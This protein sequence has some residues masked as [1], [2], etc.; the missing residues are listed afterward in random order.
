[1]PWDDKE[2]YLAPDAD[3]PSTC[4]SEADPCNPATG[5][6]T[7]DEIDISDNLGIG[8]SRHYQSRGLGEFGRSIGI[9]WSHS[10]SAQMYAIPDDADL[11]NQ[12][13]SRSGSY[14]SP[15]D[16]CLSGWAE[17]SEQSHGGTLNGATAVFYNGLCQI[18][19]AGAVK[20]TLPIRIVNPYGPVQARSYLTHTITRANG[21][22]YHFA[23]VNGSWVSNENKMA[24]LNANGTRWNLTLSDGTIE[25][26]SE[27]GRITKKTDAQ[28]RVTTYNYNIDAK[29]SQVT[30]PFGQTLTFEYIDEKLSRVI[31]PDGAVRYQYDDHDNLIQVIYP[32]G[33]SRHYLYE[34][35]LYPHL[36]TGLVDENDN[37]IAT[38]EYDDQGRVVMNERANGTEHYE[39]TYNSDGTT[40]VVDGAGATRLY[41]FEVVDGKRKLVEV[42]GDRCDHCSHGDDQARAYDENGYIESATD[43]NGH[44]T[45]FTRDEQGHELQRIEAAG[46]DDARSI[47]TEW[48][49]DF[50]K[51]VRITE[52]DRITEFVYDDKGRLLSK[53]ERPAP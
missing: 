20:A 33:N 24:K 41:Q 40:A 44:V 14:S 49:A 6:V 21:Q 36:L 43:W 38:W 8:F 50:N 9:N 19:R 34:D 23:A 7:L 51:P 52:P 35:S 15:E 27:Y 4:L 29:L 12:P 26:Y 1:M 5:N 53:T 31:G 10:Y 22:R 46:T 47:T 32:D 13:V 42:T 16:A 28:G 45:S 39:F 48:H 30:G 37:R 3:E 11:P 25:E 2:H 17:L 18:E